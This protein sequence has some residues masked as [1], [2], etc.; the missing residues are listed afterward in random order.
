MIKITMYN[1]YMFTTTMF[2]VLDVLL[3]CHVLPMLLP[4]YSPSVPCCLQL[5]KCVISQLLTANRFPS[6]YPGG[7]LAKMIKGGIEEEKGGGGRREGGEREGGRERERE[8]E[9]ERGN[10]IYM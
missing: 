2:F 9:R 8:R 6:S 1:M 5:S 3:T 7:Q 4:H 10:I